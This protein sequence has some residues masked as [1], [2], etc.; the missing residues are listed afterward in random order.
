MNAKQDYRGKDRLNKVQKSFKR[1]VIRNDQEFY[2]PLSCPSFNFA[3]CC[4]VK[5]YWYAEIPTNNKGDGL[6]VV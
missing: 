2:T 4:K 6:Q 5:Q 3:S 1:F